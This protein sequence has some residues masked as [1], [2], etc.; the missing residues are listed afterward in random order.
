MSKSRDVST[1]HTSKRQAIYIHT[2]TVLPCM[3]EEWMSLQ[4]QELSDLLRH[5]LNLNKS[6]PNAADDDEMAS[7]LDNIV[8]NF[9]DYAAR[10][11]RLA[12]KDVC[13]F[14][15]QSW[16]TTF[17]N[18]I[19]WI[20]GCRPSSYFRLIY[21]LCGAEI[22]SRLSQF[23]QG[24]V[25]VFICLFEQHDLKKYLIDFTLVS[26]STDGSSSEFPV[27][28]AIQ[29]S[30]IDNLQRRTIVQEEK[31]STK[32]ASLQQEIADMPLAL[33]A[34]KSSPDYKLNEEA[35]DAIGKI[36]E[37]MVC[38]IEEADELRLK[39]YQELTKILTRAQALDYIIAVKKLRLCVRAWG[40][41][42]DQERAR[43]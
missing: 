2:R 19:S 32:L 1:F 40:I 22:D 33:I 23:F 15:S 4:E 35:I 43:E 25:L 29:L 27:L 9:K 31:L 37:A 11:R 20:G 42:K 10:R 26:K 24:Y 39:T 5:S 16:R 30:S 17:E 18:S 6:V 7:L 36:E 38:T 28:S 41:E 14:F 34:R 3:Y 13:G 12:R 21:A 8:H